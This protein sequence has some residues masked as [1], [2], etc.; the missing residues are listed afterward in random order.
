MAMTRRGLLLSAAAAGLQAA[1]GYQAKVAVQTYVWTQYLNKQKRS[2]ADGVE[3]VIAGCRA[4]GFENAEFMSSFFSPEL[5]DKTAGLLR[6]HGLSVPICYHGGPMHTEQGAEQVIRETLELAATLKPLGTHYINTNPIPKPG[7]ALKTDQELATQA[8]AVNRLGAELAKRGMEL[9]LHHHDPEMMENAREWRHLLRNTNLPLCIDLMWAA[10]GGQDPLSIL[11][12]AGDRVALIHV[13][14]MRNG[15]CTEA[16]GDG[17]IDYS[18]IVE[19]LKG[20]GWQGWA[21]VELFHEPG[22]KVTRSLGEN[23]RLSRV[24]IEKTFQA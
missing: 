5:K 19:Y 10:R 2:L 3:D 7:K 12:E 15:L 18:K 1:A 21:I 8:K 24:W 9:V 23:L 4:A 16:A 14:N 22:T 6:K 20:R 17:D 11:K 13:R